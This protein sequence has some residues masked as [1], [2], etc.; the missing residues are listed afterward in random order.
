MAL[1]C[2]IIKYP[3]PVADW[4]FP[5]E[6]D[7][8]SESQALRWIG[9]QN[10]LILIKLNQLLAKET[11]MGQDL[12]TVENAVAAESTVVDSAIVL[13]GQLS[14]QIAAFANDPTELAALVDSINTKRDALAAAVVANTPAAPAAEPAPA[15]APEVPADQPAP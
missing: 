9:Y 6:T 13:L 2:D 8:E 7:E 11:Q 4:R 3:P 10:D 15:P 5:W 1:E 12:T 14:A